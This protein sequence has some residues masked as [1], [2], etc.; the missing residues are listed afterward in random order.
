MEVAT[1]VAAAIGE[2][3]PLPNQDPHMAERH[4]QRP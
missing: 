2:L 1:F 3:L 4:N